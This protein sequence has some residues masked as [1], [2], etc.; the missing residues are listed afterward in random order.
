MLND[1][2]LQK[3]RKGIVAVVKSNG[4]RLSGQIKIVVACIKVEFMHGFAVCGQPVGEAL[5]KIADRALKQQD[6]FCA[7]KQVLQVV[8][9]DGLFH[10]AM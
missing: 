2:F 9:E 8:L 1:V 5:K 7:F 6:V 3:F 4:M 10:V